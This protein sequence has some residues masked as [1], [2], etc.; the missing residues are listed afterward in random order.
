MGDFPSAPSIVVGVDGSRAAIQAALWAVDEAVGRDAPLRLV[1][2]IDPQELSGAA[3]DHAPFAV[4]RTALYEAQRAVEAT[5]KPVKIETEMLTGKPAIELAHEARSAVMVCVGSI[6]LR[7]A[8]HGGGSVAAVL[9]RIA[10]CP[11]AI[12]RAPHRRGKAIGRSVVVEVDNGVVLRHAFEEANLRRAPLR[13]IATWRAEAPDDI[14]DGSRLARALLNRRIARW[15]RLYPDTKIEPTV[16]RGGLCEYLAKN[17]DSVEVFVTGA[18][19]GH[20]GHRGAPEC[21]V[22]SIPPGNL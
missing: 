21:S 3:P 12:I 4:A 9:P 22:L 20:L 1:F 19:D 15:T 7:R 14:A 13:A 17:T 11:V 8:C 6:G 18:R 16:V 2:V 5:G 10:C